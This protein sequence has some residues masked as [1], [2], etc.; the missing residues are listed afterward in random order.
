[1]ASS[2]S[3]S[4]LA[5][6]RA[7]VLSLCSAPLIFLGGCASVTK[8][9]SQSIS[10]E[11][12]PP[13]ALC[14]LSREGDGE[15][16]KFR[17]SGSS[18]TVKKARKDIA[19]VCSAPGYEPKKEWLESSTD[20]TALAGMAIDGGLTDMVTGA[21]WVYPDK[22]QLSLAPVRPTEVTS[23][24]SIASNQSEASQVSKPNEA[25]EQIVNAAQQPSTATPAS[26]PAQ[27]VLAPEDQPPSSTSQNAVTSVAPLPSTPPA[28]VAVVTSPSVPN[29]PLATTEVKPQAQAGS[30]PSPSSSST[31]RALV[32]GNNRYT[33]V[34]S[35]DNATTD[36]DSF[37]KALASFGFQVSHHKDLKERDF[38][39]VLREFNAQLRGGDEVVFFYA[40]HGVQLDGQN[41]LLPT[42]VGSS[43]AD[44]VRD[45]SIPLQRVLD[46][47][48]RQKARFTLAVVDACRDNPFAGRTRSAIA[49]GLAPTSVA[50]GQIII[51]SA[52]SGQQALDR[53]S[54]NDKNPNGLFTRVFLK[55]VKESDS[56]IDRVI[57]EVRREVAETAR[58]VGHEQV[59]AIYDQAIGDFYF[60]AARN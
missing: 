39:K 16:G 50:T 25:S 32:I 18:V 13:S 21:M 12:S 52:G 51:F 7:F 60:K 35:L 20:K 33:T 43:T 34:P 58:K 6:P 45:E 31:K 26:N 56:T 40:G 24:D 37:A 28:P 1:M 17:G 49:R 5:T 59:P 57:R 48:N 46:D 38:K 41:F 22:V 27:T 55:K 30:D 8:G 54:D 19:V 29:T 15:L 47:F 4:I 11:V 10:F 9:T 53:L 23:S 14:V 36:A 44:Q 3:I 42:D 2:K